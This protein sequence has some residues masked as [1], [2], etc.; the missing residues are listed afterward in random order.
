MRFMR[1]MRFMGFMGFM[2]FKVQ[3]SRFR[4]HGQC[5]F[6]YCANGL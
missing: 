3:G 4:A 2:R 5:S 6:H 1:F